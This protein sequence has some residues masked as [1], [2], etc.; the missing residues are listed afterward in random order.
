MCKPLK[1]KFPVPSG[2][3]ESLNI[4]PIDFQSLVFWGLISPV[5]G[6]RVGVPDVELEFLIPQGSSLPL[7]SLLIVTHHGW[8]F[9]SGVSVSLP[10]IWSRH[11]PFIF[12]CG[13]SVHSVSRFLSEGIIPQVCVDN[14]VRGRR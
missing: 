10:L 14:C 13:G 12:S 11:H 9:S 2:F 3:L 8:V 6:P 1:S 4:I 5:Q 7:I